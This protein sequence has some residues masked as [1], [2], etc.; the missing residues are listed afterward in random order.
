MTIDRSD[1]VAALAFDP[2]SHE[3][4]R[5]GYATPA[6]DTFGRHFFSD[7]LLPEDDD[8]AG[9]APK[10]TFYAQPI[11]VAA[12]V[13][14]AALGSWLDPNARKYEPATYLAFVPPE[15]RGIADGIVALEDRRV[16]MRFR[17]FLAVRRT[18]TVEYAAYCVWRHPMQPIWLLNLKLLVLQFA[19]F[20]RFL[21]DVAT[22]FDRPRR[23]QIYVNARQMSRSVVLGFG[24]GWAEPYRDFEEPSRCWDEQFQLVLEHDGEVSGIDVLV[25][26]FAD[27]FDLAYGST[28]GRA[29]NLR[30]DRVGEITF[31]GERY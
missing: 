22:A 7:L 29:H 25:G 24:E 20:V 19:Q 9:P 10:V 8:Q 27:R 18:G 2:L 17:R 26:S 16:D 21:D 23:W 28:R 12:P 5:L 13:D 14:V 30:G 15:S 6:E 4:W 3:R 31:G 1:A 11:G